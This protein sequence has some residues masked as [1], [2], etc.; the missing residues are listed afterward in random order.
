M[1]SLRIDYFDYNNQ[2]MY[3]HY[4]DVCWDTKKNVANCQSVHP[5][6]NKVTK[7]FV[8]NT[9]F[10]LLKNDDNDVVHCEPI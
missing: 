2:N 6:M 1:C 3:D 8:K 10:P 4:V 5:R 7:D 9:L